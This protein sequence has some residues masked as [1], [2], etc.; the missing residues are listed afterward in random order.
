MSMRE[1]MNEE[2][3][4]AGLC[5]QEGHGDSNNHSLQQAEKHLRKH[6]TTNLEVDG[7]QQ[8]RTTSGSTP[9]CREQEPGTAMCRRSPKTG[10]GRLEK[11]H[12]ACWILIPAC[13]VDM[14]G[15]EIRI[16]SLNPWPFDLWLLWPRCTR[17]ITATSSMILSH[18]SSP[19]TSMN[20]TVRPL[21]S[22]RTGD[23]QNQGFTR[24]S[25]LRRDITISQKSVSMKRNL[26]FSYWNIP[27]IG[28]FHSFILFLYC[29]PCR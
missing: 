9:V 7:L 16:T 24:F 15:S 14:V 19:T 10:S 2:N 6:N 11:R 12:V 5:W 26:V 8:K 1:V 13:H 18:R 21:G 22:G 23:S 29:A 25:V 3:V 17:L 20:M 27:C 4:Q 28:M